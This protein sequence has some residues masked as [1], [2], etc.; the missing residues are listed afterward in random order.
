M[1]HLDVVRLIFD[2][3]ANI[4]SEIP[5]TMAYGRRDFDLIRLEEMGRTVVGLISHDGSRTT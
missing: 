4:T 1:R 5:L 2:Y 3:G